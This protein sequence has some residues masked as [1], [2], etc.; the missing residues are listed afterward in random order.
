MYAQHRAYGKKMADRLRKLTVADVQLCEDATLDNTD[1]LLCRC[2]EVQE[3]IAYDC[4]G[5]LK[6]TSLDCAYYIQNMIEN[7]I[8]IHNV[9]MYDMVE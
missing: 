4:K 9:H 6:C 7:F 1:N 8:K 2:Q 5:C 3:N